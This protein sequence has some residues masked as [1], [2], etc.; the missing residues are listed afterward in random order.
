MKKHL[1]ILLA[2]FFI[3]CHNLLAFISPEKIKPEKSL[4]GAI[5]NL[6]DTF[7][8]AFNEEDIDL[9]G[10]VVSLDLDTFEN[11]FK[12]RIY[13]S[14]KLTDKRIRLQNNGAKVS[15]RVI[16][17]FE[18]IT[19]LVNQTESYNILITVN[20]KIKNNGAVIFSIASIVEK[21]DFVVI[22]NSSVGK[23]DEP[24]EI[25]VFS[26]DSGGNSDIDS[27]S[28]NSTNSTGSKK[29]TE[30]NDEVEKEIVF[31][32]NTFNLKGLKGSF[33]VSSRAGEKNIDVKIKTKGGESLI[34]PHFFRVSD[35]EIETVYS[36][37]KNI[38]FMA[39]AKDKNGVLWFGRGGGGKIF[40]SKDGETASEVFN[41]ADCLIE[42]NLP[43]NTRIED[44]AVDSSNRAHLVFY[45]TER[46][47]S[48]SLKRIV[49]G[50]AVVDTGKENITCGDIFLLIDYDLTTEGWKG[51]EDYPF[52]DT[53]GA[54][55]LF[56]RALPADDSSVWL[57]GSDGGVAN[58]SDSRDEKYYPVFTRTD[59]IKT[60]IASNISPTAIIDRNKNIWFGTIVG[61]NKYDKKRGRFYLYKYKSENK[62]NLSKLNPLEEYFDAIATLIQDNKNIAS[63]LGDI[64][65]KKEIGNDLVK[66]DLIWSSAIDKT[67]KLWFGTLGGGI[68]LFEN[69]EERKDLH[70]TKKDGLISNIIL[71]IAVDDD[72]NIWIGTEQGVSKIKVQ[73]AKCK[74][75]NFSTLDG[76]GYGPVWDITPDDNS[77]VWFATQSGIYRYKKD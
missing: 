34:L 23:P 10:S 59:S 21:P 68:R 73:N 48:N 36:D 26:A 19:T 27:A 43:D 64:N 45:G 76:I 17:T 55:S 29:Q 9:L 61:V 65:F 38:S 49:A 44:I 62:L 30:F 16:Q 69:G 58:F 70:L 14:F 60:S 2:F 54:R 42:K 31:N 4:E 39:S 24:L 77:N 75:Q 37:D 33:S 18:D 66:E 35:K 41:L 40:Q 51:D 1:L 57:F 52:Y 32:G 50:D 72:N 6:L 53:T 15:A 3:N 8:K 22:R 67:G 71:S 13:L 25:E 47:E 74:V 46:D 20:K 7:E 56:T 63:G 5:E 12:N 11:N 28:I